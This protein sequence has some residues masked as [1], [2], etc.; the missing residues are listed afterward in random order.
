MVLGQR[1][2]VSGAWSEELGQWCMAVVLGQWCLVMVS[3][4]VMDHKRWVSGQRQF[5]QGELCQTR[6]CANTE[7]PITA[8]S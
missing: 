1:S 4:V 2:L 5:S 8:M 6:H 7:Y 3:G